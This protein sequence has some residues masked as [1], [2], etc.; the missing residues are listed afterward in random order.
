[1]RHQAR[2]P[3]NET[4]AAPVERRFDHVIDFP[5]V[6]PINGCI[7]LHESMRECCLS[8][9]GSSMARRVETEEIEVNWTCMTLRGP[10]CA[11]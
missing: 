7:V 2:F 5:R 9:P 6:S 8:G 10:R 1:M 3:R 4:D 11:R